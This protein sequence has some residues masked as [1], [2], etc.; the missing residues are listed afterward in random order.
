[1]NRARPALAASATVLA[2]AL[3]FSKPTHTGGL[4]PSSGAFDDT[5]DQGYRTFLRS[6]F[7]EG[8]PTYRCLQMVTEMPV[9]EAIFAQCPTSDKSTEPVLLV[10]LRESVDMNEAYSTQLS[11]QQARPRVTTAKI[12]IELFRRLEDVWWRMAST[13]AYP[14]QRR[15][16]ADGTR[17][18][19]LTFRIG[20]GARG[21]EITSPPAGTDP[22][23]L[24]NLGNL[25]ARYV[26][27][28]PGMRPGLRTALLSE[29]DTLAATL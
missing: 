26:D 29:A 10:H 24:A 6:A 20:L 18:H 9:A 21:G 3:A 12:D 23:H 16:V 17:F 13:T 14:E 8:Q 4:E 1:M 7:F 25:L 11:P 19:F 22:A 5:A 15:L 28:P 27:S 2:A